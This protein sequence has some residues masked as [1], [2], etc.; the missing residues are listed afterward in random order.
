MSSGHLKVIIGVLRGRVGI[1]AARVILDELHEHILARILLGAHEKHMLA[2]MGQARKLGGVEQI[3]GVYVER[4]GRAIC[5]R[6]THEQ[7]LD[8]VV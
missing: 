4:S 1:T 2:K 8:A 6:V 7:T 3:A 5:Q